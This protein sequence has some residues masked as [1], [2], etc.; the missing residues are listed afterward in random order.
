MAHHGSSGFYTFLLAKIINKI[1]VCKSAI[2][3]HSHRDRNTAAKK[4]KSKTKTNKQKAICNFK[5]N[6][7]Q[8][9]NIRFR[10]ISVCRYVVCIIIIYTHRSM[11]M[12]NTSIK[13]FKQW[14]AAAVVSDG[15]ESMAARQINAK[16]QFA[17][18]T[19]MNGHFAIFANQL[20]FNLLISLL[21]AHCF[22]WLRLR[23]QWADQSVF[24]FPNR[25]ID[26][27]AIIVCWSRTPHTHCPNACGNRKSVFSCTDDGLGWHRSCASSFIACH[28]SFAV[29]HSRGCPYCTWIEYRN[30]DSADYRGRRHVQMPSKR[31]V[32]QTNLTQAPATHSQF[33]FN[34]IRRGVSA[35]FA[36]PKQFVQFWPHPKQ[37]TPLIVGSSVFFIFDGNRNGEWAL[38][39]VHQVQVR[40]IATE[41]FEYSFSVA[42]R[43]LRHH[44]NLARKCLQIH[45]RYARLWSFE[46]A[47]I[48]AFTRKILIEGLMQES[49]LQSWDCHQH[50][51]R[52][53]WM[54]N[55][56]CNFASYPLTTHMCH[57]HTHSHAHAP[58]AWFKR[59]ILP[60]R[61]ELRLN[62]IESSNAV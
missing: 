49:P 20:L 56:N 58:C 53:D 55:F 23:L 19:T 10:W 51:E 45:S 18:R 35:L 1:I 46:A 42:Q 6:T 48:F 37:L 43:K 50:S 11:S 26:S 8:F 44:R 16:Y 39:L 61:P 9:N 32:P 13:C 34:S 30:D 47:T 57:T 3:A 27:L 29:W 28:R 7:E 5:V 40:A 31:H 14:Y 21:F 33:E 59:R 36:L 38:N 2:A 15:A 4:S 24:I 25:R 62:E 22:D 12:H 52:P 17:M 60:N 41:F 54:H